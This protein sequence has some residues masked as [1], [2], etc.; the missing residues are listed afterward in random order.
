LEEALDGLAVVV[1]GTG[2]M[3]GGLA[4][5]IFGV[6]LELL[7]PDAIFHELEVRSIRIMH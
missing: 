3:K 1:P 2:P 7:F 6:E 5:V 4:L